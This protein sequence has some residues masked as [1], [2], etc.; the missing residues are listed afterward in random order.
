LIEFLPSKLV[1]MSGGTIMVRREIPPPSKKGRMDEIIENSHV[2]DRLW[3][4]R[5]WFNARGGTGPH[6]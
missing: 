2:V 3:N 5:L 6:G 1:V 4:D